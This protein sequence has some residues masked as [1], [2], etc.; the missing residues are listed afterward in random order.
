MS[1]RN[2]IVSTRC[3]RRFSQQTVARKTLEQMVD[4]ARLSASA[5]NLQPLKY[6]LSCD[7]ETNAII[8]SHLAWAGFLEGWGGPQEF[9]RPT[10]YILVL[11][12]KAIDESFA[13]DAGIAA[14]SIRLGVTEIGLGSC[15]LG[16]IKRQ[17]LA[18]ALKI[19]A[20]YEIVLAIAIG[21]PGE[22][23]TLEAV[24]EDGNTEYWRDD[25]GV[26]H[27]PKRSLAEI[28]IN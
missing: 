5:R 9:E 10:A 11:G 22:Q 25:E 24:D 7:A 21:K 28:L 14:Q 1:L 8:F 13:T 4:L 6:F 26:H 18:Q 19:S 3:Y 27:V 20:Q 2:L 15:V 16:S 12:D 23:V 17:E